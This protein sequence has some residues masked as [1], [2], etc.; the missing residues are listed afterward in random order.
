MPYIKKQVFTKHKNEIEISQYHSIRNP[1]PED[2]KKP[3]EQRMKKVNITS[4]L[5]REINN[6]NAEDNLRLLIMQN[7]RADDIYLTVT[8]K[9]DNES[10]APPSPP[11]AEKI[12]GNFI[13]RIKRF[14]EKNGCDLKYIIVTECKKIRIH[15]HML[16]NA[17]FKISIQ[18]LK[19]L[20][21]QGSIKKETYQGEAV[22]AARIANYF[23]KKKHSAFYTDEHVFRQRWKPSRNLEKVK[24][25]KKK[26]VS[27]GTW[28][29]DIVV[30]KG[31][32]LDKT[33]V[34]IGQTIYGYPYRF[35]RLVRIV[36]RI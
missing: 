15:H 30:P 20:W 28:R 33:S 17:P 4:D 19:E 26:I 22:D 24:P 7:F 13:R 31:Y 25:A 11:E 14:Y 2:K 29:K 3:K 27:A 34:R 9:N 10:L 21:G 8:Y 5:Q 32:Y 18:K 12:I 1:S 23:I 36:R 35:Y 16:L 6:R